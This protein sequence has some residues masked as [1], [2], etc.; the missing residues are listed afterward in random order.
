MWLSPPQASG[1][2]ACM[3]TCM[4]VCL[5]VG[6][7]VGMYVSYHMYIIFTWQ[8]GGNPQFGARSASEDFLGGRGGGR[9]WRELASKF[10]ADIAS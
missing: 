4:C 10:P 3:Q 8:F 7:Y 6:L 2:H 1:V 5:C 9:K